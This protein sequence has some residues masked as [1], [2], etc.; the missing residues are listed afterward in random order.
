MQVDEGLEQAFVIALTATQGLN[1]VII[2]NLILDNIYSDEAMNGKILELNCANEGAMYIGNI[3]FKSINI[4]LPTGGT[5]GQYAVINMSKNASDAMGQLVGSISFIDSDIKGYG[6]NENH[7]CI[8]QTG[9]GQ[10]LRLRAQNTNLSRL[11]SFVHFNGSGIPDDGYFVQFDNVTLNNSLQAV[12]S[13]VSPVEIHANNMKNIGS[14]Y[15]IIRT[16]ITTITHTIYG[17]NVDWATIDPCDTVSGTGQIRA[18]GLG[19]RTKAVNLTPQNGDYV[20]DTDDSRPETWNGSA[21]VAM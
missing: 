19:L 11:H 5:A 3:T 18:L 15:G 4:Q 2:D 20:W 8:Y 10:I 17:N 9:K 13:S 7:R 6:R 1:A 21:W 12:S 16:N 14:N